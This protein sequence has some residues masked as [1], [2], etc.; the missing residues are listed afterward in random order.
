MSVFP[1]HVRNTPVIGH[2]NAGDLN[3]CCV[4]FCVQRENGKFPGMSSYA[5]LIR[6][7]PHYKSSESV[8]GL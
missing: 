2:E 4:L 5:K 7:G 8:M 3:V 6:L 1:L